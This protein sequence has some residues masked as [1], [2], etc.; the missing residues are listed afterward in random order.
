MTGR[1][2][3]TVI[4]Y[5]F[6]YAWIAAVCAL[7]T[8]C[9]AAADWKFSS[10]FNYD[11]G[12]YGTTARTDTVYI[13]FTLKRYYNYGEVSVT[14]PYLRQSSAE[15]ITRVGGL[16]ALVK[17]R[18]ATA[19][20][21]RGSSGPG[22]ILVRGT[23]ELK[24][25][26]ADSFDLS[27]AGTLKLPAADREKGLGTGEPDEGVGVEFAKDVTPRWTLLTDA[28][29]TIIGD[30]PG[31]DLKDQFAFDIG[32]SRPFSGDILITVLYATRSALVS[33]NP[34]PREL[35]CTAEHRAGNGNRYSGGLLLGLSEGSPD[36]GLSIGLS[37]RF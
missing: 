19:G 12:K 33:G 20:A 15:T 7:M 29:V 17:K 4:R 6:I 24:K 31:A 8:P 21:V 28:Y 3:R 9:G 10:S 26:A 13:P 30:P 16:P 5:S 32:F 22:D 25:N 1:P 18:S 34:D 36:I 23:Y 2:G 11:T 35:S 27:L 14:V 37:R